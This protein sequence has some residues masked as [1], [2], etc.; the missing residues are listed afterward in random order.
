MF[1]LV[2]HDENQGFS[3]FFLN[4]FMNLAWSSLLLH[5]CCIIQCP[6]QHPDKFPEGL[7]LFTVSQSCD[8]LFFSDTNLF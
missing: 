5:M 8:L 3:P 6:L 7:C 4:I 1:Y 2:Y